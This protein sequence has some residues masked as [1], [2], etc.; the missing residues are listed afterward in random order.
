MKIGLT[1]DLKAGLTIS[2]GSPDDAYEEYDSPET[3]EA[4]G[5]IIRQRGHEIIKLGGG[6]EFLRRVIDTPPDFV[7]NIAEGQ[8]NYRSRE[9]QIPSVL[10]ILGI[11][12]SGSDPLC[13][14][15]CLDKPLTKQIAAQAG[16]ITP[17]WQVISAL[18]QFTRIDWGNFIFPLFVKPVHEGSS[19]GIRSGSRAEDVKQLKSVCG[20]L[21]EIYHQPIMVEEF[22][23]GA[24]ITVGVLDNPLRVLGIMQVVPAKGPDPDFVYSLEIKRDWEKLVRYQ[25]PAPLPESTL[26]NIE[27]MAKL[28]FTTLGCRDISR[29]DFR[30]TRDGE[31]Y[32]IEI[33][34]LPGLSPSYGDLPIMA[35]SL[36]YS[37]ED[38][39]GMILD[40]ALSRI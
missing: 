34:P 5:E 3:I 13:L 22:I 10:E 36:G 24:E 21:L 2:P 35:R 28:A 31:P 9:G 39:I 18:A 6:R 23:P 20:N 14:A 16:I 12:Y 26:K 8:G 15:L 30:V 11:P 7:F 19:K 17:R 33:N 25:C 38:L 29:V 40:N 32:F 4:I 27:R 37:Y 1:Y